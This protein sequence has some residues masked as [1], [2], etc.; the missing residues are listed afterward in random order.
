MRRAARVDANQIAIV[1]A[2]RKHGATVQHLHTVGQGCPDL[3][4]G[5]KEETVLFEVK[6]SRGAC[7]TDDQAE[8]HSA[9][10]GGALAVVY[11]VEGALRVLRLI[12]NVK[13]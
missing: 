6:S 10:K 8:W 5:Y 12:D 13:A 2:L 1:E 11:D 3:L 7:L 9:W 4:A